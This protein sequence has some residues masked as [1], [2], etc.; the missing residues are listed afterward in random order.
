MNIIE[1]YL[2]NELGASAV[3]FALFAP[4]LLV[5][6][7]GTV[8]FGFFT[9]ERMRIQNVAQAAASYVSQVQSD[10]D[11]Q[12]IAQESYTGDYDD[13][14]L[15]SQFVCTCS[16]GTAQ[17]CPVVC[18]EDDYQRRFVSVSVSGNF[19]PILPYPGLAE[20]LNLQSTVRMRVD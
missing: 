3:E 15:T 11:I 19:S 1:Q 18:D 6:L 17:E 7:F 4:L 20:S 16:D 13:I 10:A 5:M 12:T 14:S 8:D 9:L 2:K